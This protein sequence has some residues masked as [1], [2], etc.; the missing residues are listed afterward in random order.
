MAD[1]GQKQS[2][3]NMFQPL[4][5]PDREA[6]TEAAIRA[7]FDQPPAHIAAVNSLDHNQFLHPLVVPNVCSIPLR[8]VLEAFSCLGPIPYGRVWLS[9]LDVAELANPAQVRTAEGRAYIQKQIN[10]SITTVP[11]GPPSMEQL[12]NIMKSVLGGFPGLQDCLGKI[13]QGS[14][15]GSGEADLNDV[16]DQVQNVLVGPLMQ[17]LQASNPNCPD[18]SPALKQILDGFRGLNAIVTGKP[19][20]SQ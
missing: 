13:V 4:T 15:D 16:V 9:L 8:E 2:L 3:Q 10:H 18:I 20:P 14:N 17:S 6:V 7:Y 12:D 1:E 5:I 11:T 19:P